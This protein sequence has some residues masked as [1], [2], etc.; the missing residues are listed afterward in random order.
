[1]HGLIL[2][3]LQKFAH[4]AIGSD[5]WREAL[6]KEGLNQQSFSSGSVYEDTQAIEQ[7]VLASSIL[8]I[9][10][11]QVVESFG[12]FLSKELI[13]LYQRVIKPAWKTLE[14]IENTETFIHSA[15]RAGNPG[16]VPPVLDA[17]RISDNQL[18]LLYSSDRKLCQLAIGIIKGMSSHFRE[19]IEIHHDSC[20]HKGDPYCSFRLIR[21]DL[22]QDT[23]NIELDVTQI[24]QASESKTVEKS[25]LHSTPSGN[26]FAIKEKP[27]KTDWGKLLEPAIVPSDIASI[28]SYRLLAIQG[29]G[30]MGC[31]FKSIDTRTQQVYAIKVLEPKVAQDELGR[32]RFRREWRALQLIDHP[33][34]VEVHEVGEINSLPYLVMEFLSGSSL[35]TYRSRFSS[36]PIHEIL[37]I[38]I[39]TTEGLLHIHQSGLIHRDLKPE[40]LWIESPSLSVK[41]ID[42]GL[43]HLVKEELRL[44]R[45]GT[46]IGT[47]SF[48]AP[49]QASG[50]KTDFRTDFFA[51]GCILYDLITGKRPF[52]RE[53]ILS[54]FSALANHNPPEP[55]ELVPEIPTKL[56]DLI[57]SMLEKKPENRPSSCQ[58]ILDSLIQIRTN[59]I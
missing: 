7:I 5:I 18:Q 24:A 28:G 38:A 43:A 49:E 22:V 14:I 45:T 9:P 55:I 47:P 29:E 56:S 26:S 40:N 37:R 35:Q 4:Q 3:Q 6:A 2:V 8:G 27:K 41:I 58:E 10:V 30:G 50:L 59:L 12:V 54:T 39:E 53:S 15:V 1:M 44:T 33:R 19:V 31:V 52:D 32:Q 11:D 51:L 13:R 46:F 21:H 57:M 34:I 23:N 25:P 42:F 20:M 16:A 36:L 48:M 17:I